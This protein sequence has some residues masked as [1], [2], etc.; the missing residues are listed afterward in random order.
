STD[1]PAVTDYQQI[2][3]DEP[4]QR[5]EALTHTVREAEKTLTAKQ[6][7]LAF[8][9]TQHEKLSSTLQETGETLATHTAQWQKICLEGGFDSLTDSPASLNDI[10]QHYDGLYQQQQ[11]AQEARRALE[12]QVLTLQNR[13]QAEEAE[14]ERLSQAVQ[15]NS[16]EQQFLTQQQTERSARL[17]QLHQQQQTLETSLT[18]TVTAFGYTIPSPAEAAEW[19]SQRQQESD[20]FAANEQQIQQSAQQLAELT[21]QQQNL[22]A[23]QAKLTTQLAEQ[24][25]ALAALQQQHKAVTE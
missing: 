11:Q 4:A 13:L 7:Q 24:S 20:Q 25:A 15:R 9:R 2:T 18:Q 21:A 17:T 19:L 23:Q 5:L 3:P 12:T 16:Q 8:T 14:C 6:S 10:T 22:E 1:H